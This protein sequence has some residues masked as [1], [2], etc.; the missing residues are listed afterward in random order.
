M[1]RRAGTLGGVTAALFGA[2]LAGSV[3]F[4]IVWGALTSLKTRADALASPPRWLFEP[5]LTH[6]RAVLAQSGQLRPLLNSLLIASASAALALLLGVPLA[7]AASR[8]RFRGA[9]TI[10]LAL[11]S[12]RMAPAT[13]IAL[14][15]FLIF[16]R[17]QLIDSYAAIILVHAAVG[18]ALA[19]WVMKG[20]F[21][22]IPTDI[23]EA[24]LLDGSGRLMTLLAQVLPACLP[25]LV[26][27]AAFCF[28]NSWN[29]FFLALMLTGYQ[30]R[31][32]T[33]AIPGLVTPHGTYWGEVAAISTISVVPGLLFAIA[34]RRF[35]V[36]ELQGGMWS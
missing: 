2:L 7:Y 4:P 30:S 24:S 21:D 25:G 1:S 31:P 35:A 33:V 32:L 18:L 27:T 22:E 15:L 12:V 20:F 13:T 28:V 5:T 3:L 10:L 16:T 11:M 23:D 26:A 19:T 29:E 6:Y 8:R 14:P 17:L 34:A 9:R 36:R